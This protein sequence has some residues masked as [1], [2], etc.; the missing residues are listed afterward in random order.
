MNVLLMT[1]QWQHLQKGLETLSSNLVLPDL[2]PVKL[3]ENH[4]TLSP[5][6]L[7]DVMPTLAQG[8]GWLMFPSEV[9]RLPASVSDD[10]PAL[11][12]EALVGD[13][14]W[15]LHYS[16]DGQWALNRFQVTLSDSEH[17]TH[18]A[19]AVQHLA[20]G[21]PWDTLEYHQ[22]WTL[23]DSGRPYVEVAILV[24]MKENAR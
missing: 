17:A 20:D 16:G 12:A 18:L 10:S 3:T 19:S 13:E 24:D 2:V 7:A 1:Q 5:A 9:V 23:D 21:E 14:T 15:Q 6:Q 4:Q 22:L 11:Q 8:R